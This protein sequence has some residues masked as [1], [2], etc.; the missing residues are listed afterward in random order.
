MPKQPSRPASQPTE[1]PIHADNTKG[2]NGPA[3]AKASVK[4]SASPAPPPTSAKK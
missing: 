3:P 2:Y 1:R 4:P